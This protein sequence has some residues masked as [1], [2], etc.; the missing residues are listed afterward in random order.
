MKIL[1]LRIVMP[2]PKSFIECDAVFTLH[3][4]RNKQDRNP[5]SH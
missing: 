3:G 1:T 4:N 2:M 5:V